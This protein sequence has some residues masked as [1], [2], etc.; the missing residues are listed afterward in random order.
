M[1]VSSLFNVFSVS[2]SGLDM[3]NTWLSAISENVANAD[4]VTTTSNPAFQERFVVSQNVPGGPSGV[5][6]GVA[7]DGVALG[8]AAGVETYDPNNPLADA[9]GMVRRANIDMGEQMSAMMVAERGYQANLA[10]VSRAQSAY[11]AAISLGQNA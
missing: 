9:K 2:G 6:A 10:V 5:G 7:I 1:T 11:Q 4:D 3:Y 8:S